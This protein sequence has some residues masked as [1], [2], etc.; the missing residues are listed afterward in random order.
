MDSNYK[1]PERYIQARSY[2]GKT[3]GIIIDR[4][5]GSAHPKHPDMIYPVNYGYIPNTVGG[6][7]EE[8][9]VYLLGLNK[10]V[11]E[12]EAKVIGIVHRKNDNEDKLIAAPDGISL[13]KE[14]IENAIS[15]QEKYF[16]HMI[17]I[18]L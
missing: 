4:P 5:L 17:E 1:F 3:V 10:S 2:L 15:F 14:E 12:Y 7:S 16:D 11:T 8:L 9:D 18:L 13:S 6:D